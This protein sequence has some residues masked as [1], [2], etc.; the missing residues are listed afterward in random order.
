MPSASEI[1]KI[2][3]ETINMLNDVIIQWSFP[4]LNQLESW[5]FVLNQFWPLCLP[6][7]QLPF[8]WLISQIQLNA[9]MSVQKSS[10][11]IINFIFK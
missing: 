2:D 8:P 1:I 6:I 4:H 5:R 11:A 10:L 3:F 9:A 7:T